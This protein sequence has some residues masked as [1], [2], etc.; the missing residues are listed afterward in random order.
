MSNLSKVFPQTDIDHTFS[1]RVP[2]SGSFF[3]KYPETPETASLINFMRVGK[4]DVLDTISQRTWKNTHQCDLGVPFRNDV[5]TLM[6][7]PSNIILSN[8]TLPQRCSQQEDEIHF[9]FQSTRIQGTFEL[10]KESR[11]YTHTHERCAELKSVI[12]P[13]E[14][15]REGSQAL[16]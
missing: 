3:G 4:K 2:I 14:G 16:I 10:T 9:L 7:F 1:R 13:N 11:S 15:R 12:D 5:G 8:P 6:S